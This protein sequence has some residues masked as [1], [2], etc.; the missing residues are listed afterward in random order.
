MPLY[1]SG[2]P[3]TGENV[4]A[5]AREEPKIK[6]KPPAT[7]QDSV[8]ACTP[9]ACAGAAYPKAPA[10]RPSAPIAT[11]SFLSIPS[12]S[13]LPYPIVEARNLNVGSY[14]LVPCPGA[15]VSSPPVSQACRMLDST[16]CRSVAAHDLRRNL[17][18][19]HAT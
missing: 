17:R 8:P 3:D 9:C 6:P 15:T 13:C 1:C 10:E 5:S 19:R 18:P 11:A 4:Q 16:V 2:L 7:W 14:S 12:V